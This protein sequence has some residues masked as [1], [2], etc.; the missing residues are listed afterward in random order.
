MLFHEVWSF[1]HPPSWNTLVLLIPGG[2]SI[3]GHFFRLFAKYLSWSPVRPV[4]V[5][6][7]TQLWKAFPSSRLFSFVREWLLQ[8]LFGCFKPDPAFSMWFHG[9]SGRC[10]A[11]GLLT[12]HS[13]ALLTGF[14]RCY[15][16]KYR[17]ICYFLVPCGGSPFMNKSM[18][19]NDSFSVS[20]RK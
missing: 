4:R 1:F 17:Q 3:R 8:F 15:A 19:P 18:A 20:W 11:Y 12:G 10:P 2:Q 7:L 14:L 6:C 5:C 9:H 13:R 16:V